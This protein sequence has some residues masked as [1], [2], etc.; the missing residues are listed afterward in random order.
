MHYA[1]QYWMDGEYSNSTSN[2]PQI[3][4]STPSTGPDTSIAA[5][6]RRFRWL[7]S[8]H[9]YF[10]E[11][12][13]LC[14]HGPC[15]EEEQNNARTEIDEAMA[16]HG[17][18]PPLLDP[19]LGPAAPSD[20]ELRALYYSTPNF[21]AAVREALARWVTTPTPVAVAERPWERD[22][23]CDADGRCWFYRPAEIPCRLANG[24]LCRWV[25]DTPDRDGE[26]NHDTHSLPFYSLPLP[27][28]PGE[29]A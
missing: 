9:G 19:V 17:D 3:R 29:G 12:E 11:E 6:A 23:W 27:A 14:G 4:S 5:D 24:M 2:F 28:A 15:S 25:L 1:I 8:G 18:A 10:M 16:Q 22:G 13:G 26:P 20:E 21:E 7:L